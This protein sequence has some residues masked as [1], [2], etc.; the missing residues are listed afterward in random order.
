MYPSA[1]HTDRR[2]P[3]VV[4]VISEVEEYIF[5]KAEY[6]LVDNNKICQNLSLL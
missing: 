3:F 6:A 2:M 5:L 4:I 1:I